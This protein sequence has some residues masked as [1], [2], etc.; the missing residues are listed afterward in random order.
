VN[1]EYLT[2]IITAT[3][4]NGPTTT[5]IIAPAIVT[6]TVVGD[7]LNIYFSPAFVE[8][9]AGYAKAAPACGAKRQALCELQ[10][11]LQ[12]VEND[13][14]IEKFEAQL[15]DRVLK[16]LGRTADGGR[17]LIEYL[18][19]EKLKEMF[20]VYGPS[21]AKFAAV[22]GVIQI[23]PIAY[24]EWKGNQENF[25]A[26]FRGVSFKTKDV[27]VTKPQEGGNQKECPND[28]SQWV[29]DCQLA[30]PR[31]PKLTPSNSRT[32][33]QRAVRLLKEALSASQ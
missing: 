1:T 13:P 21:G 2:E 26:T 19:A 31:Y 18:G 25:A 8:K 16:A 12:A 6:A 15:I 10:A 4:N 7:D 9:L 27:K 23:A 14:E 5:N 11:F 28:Q 32:V 24:N 33:P 3:L 30:P 20:A 29:R 17:N 22:F